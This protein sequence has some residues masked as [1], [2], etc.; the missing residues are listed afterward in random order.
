M[1][2]LKTPQEIQ[3]MKAGGQILHQIKTQLIQAVKP[4]ITPSYLDSLAD[5]LIESSGGQASFKTVPGYHHATCININSGVVHG[6]PTDQPLK[7]GDLLTIDIGL[8][9]QGFHTDTSV[10]LGVGQTSSE[11]KSF[12]STGR[13]ALK[14]ATSQAR[15]GNRIGHL[16][17]ATE[18]TLTQAGY[19]PV[20]DLTGHG[21]GRQLHEPPNVP[22]FLNTSVPHTPKIRPGMVLAIEVI[23]ALGSPKLVMEN[24]DWT[25]STSDGKIAAVF[26]E[27]VAV[28]P[29]GSQILT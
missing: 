18:N 3:I 26:E 23:Y 8:L 24:D 27:T 12:L 5:Q 29:D 16:S 10:S 28:T 1:I 25:I 15:P 11:I 17:Q 13:R 19:A 9:Y 6:I 20:R 21:V 7:K 22:C 2:P 4:G 14:E